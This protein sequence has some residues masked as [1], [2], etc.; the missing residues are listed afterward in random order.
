MIALAYLACTYSPAPARLHLLAC[1]SPA[2]DLP[3]PPPYPTSPPY[4]PTISRIHIQAVIGYRDTFVDDEHLCLVMEHGDGGDFAT[5]I[6]NATR[7]F[8]ED[9]VLS[10]FAQLALALHHVH[11][12]G[13]LHRDLKTCNVFMTASGQLKLGDFGIAKLLASH[14]QGL[15]ATCAHAHSHT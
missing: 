7:P 15:A 3:T 8:T 10:W 2:P 9:Q 14:E 4:L 11:E 13:V 1:T 12:R 5:R 6:L